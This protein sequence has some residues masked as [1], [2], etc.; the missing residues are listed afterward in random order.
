MRS[1]HDPDARFACTLHGNDGTDLRFGPDEA[2]A[3]NVVGDV[4]FGTEVPGWG[5]AEGSVTLSRPDALDTLDANLFASAEIYDAAG[6]TVYE[7]RVAK[8]TRS[9]ESSL[10]VDLEGPLAALD[11]DPTARMIYRDTDL[12]N[13]TEPTKTRRYALYVASYGTQSDIQT[14]FADDG[15]PALVLDGDG[16]WSSDRICEG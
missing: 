8:L 10:T 2:E 4:S 14:E 7:G 16:T 5:F 9:G 6:Q 12:G 1:S 15:D 11:D 3:I 13:W